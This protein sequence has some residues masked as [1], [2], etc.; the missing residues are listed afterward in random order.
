MADTTSLIESSSRVEITAPALEVIE[1]HVTT[2][3]QQIAAHFNKAHRSVLLAIRRLEC[4]EEFRLHNF[5]QTVETRDNPSGGAPIQS[6]SYRITRDGFV[7]LAMGFTGKDAAR[8]KEAYIAA[9]NKMEAELQGRNSRPANPA[10]DYTRISPAQAQDLKELVHAIAAA[11]VQT[12]SETWAR[13]HKKFRV[14]SYLDLP[15]AQFEEASAYLLG[16]LTDQPKDAINPMDGPALR[17]AR[18]VALSYFTSY[19]D[20]M[21][22]GRPAP[23]PNEIPREVLEGLLAEAIL[24]QRVLITFAPG[25]GRM[26]SQLIPSDASIISLETADYTGLVRDI[27]MERLPELAEA[28]NKRVARH[29]GA[30]SANRQVEL[31]GIRTA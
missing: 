23:R 26:E 31:P 10:I 9:F 5:V 6:P 15:A 25:T 28:L 14:N 27:P 13:L 1:G 2:T 18:N 12:F 16:K 19:Q 17:A 8:W 24:R 7:F 22:A 4:S 30:L 11:K 20:A 3:S 29:L 21:K